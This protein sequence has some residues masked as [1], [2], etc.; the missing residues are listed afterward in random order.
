MNYLTEIKKLAD[1]LMEKGIA[2]TFHHFSEARMG[3]QIVVKDP[4]TQKYKWDAVCHN[5]SYGND[6]G[7]LE[8]MGDIVENDYDSVE[9]WLSAEDILKRL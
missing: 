4:E 1:G 6:E 5:F 3:Y 2:F 7:L 9:G 8:I